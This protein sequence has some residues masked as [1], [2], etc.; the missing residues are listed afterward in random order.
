MSER[1]V[2]ARNAAL[3][4]QDGRLLIGTESATEAPFQTDQQGLVGWLLQFAKP[5]APD[6]AL[7]RLPVES[8]ELAG[9]AVAYLRS[10]GVLVPADGPPGLRQSAEAEHAESRKQLASMSQGVYELAC[11]VLG[12]GPYAEQALAQRSGTG[13]APRLR[14]MN[15][16]IA[17]LRFELAA[18]R[19]PYLDGQLRA[20]GVGPESRDL[21][22]HVGCGPCHLDGW[23][24]LDIHPA[25]LATNVLWGL[26]FVDGSV[27][28]VF[29]SHLLEHLFY[30]NDVLPFLGELHRILVPGGRI[31]VIVPDI[32]QCIEAYQGNDAIFFAERRKHWG[33]GDGQPTRLE[34][35]LAYAGA[36]PDP[37]TIFEAHKFGYDFET[38][39]RALV[40]AGFVDIEQL[41]YMESRDPALRVDDHS[42]VANATHGD[43]HYSLFVE[44]T[45][46]DGVSAA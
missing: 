39:S 29:L 6:A 40:R 12:F 42:E 26:P 16:A 11:D 43:R 17:S 7:A 8:R 9:R 35:F 27:R 33:A 14:A 21:Q 31:R 10:S 15:Q 23:I 37:A 4:F 20:L 45:K 25:P 1:L 41:H 5:E 18:L 24:N 32:G 2:F 19:S 13:V 30:P 28:R 3:R 44:A 34:D 22:L 36:G 46:P 38:L